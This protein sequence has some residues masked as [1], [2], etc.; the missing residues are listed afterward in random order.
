MLAVSRAKRAKGVG[1]RPGAGTRHHPDEDAGLPPEGRAAAEAGQG[2]R[3]LARER[4][5]PASQPKGELPTMNVGVPKER[6]PFEYRVGLPPAG[7]ALFVKHG[8]TLY[9]ERGAGEGAG[10]SDDHYVREGAK[11]V[12]SKDEVYG[13]ADL[14]LKFARPLK[15]ELD[16][17]R[18]GLTLAG[19][20]HL[21]AARQDKIWMM[22][23][24]TFTVLAY[25]QIEYDDGYRPVLAPLSQIG[26][27]MVPQIASRLLQNDQGGRGILLGRVVGVPP[28]EIV[29]IGAGVVGTTAATAFSAAGAH[30]TVL[31]VD[32]R[33]LHQLQADSG[34]QVATMLSTPYNVSKLCTYADVI[35]GAVL[36]PGSRAPIVLTREMVASMKPRSVIIDMSIDEG[37]CVETSRPTT[38]A[39]PTYIEEGVI[40]FCVPN[41]SGVLGRTGTTA[42]FNGAYPYLEAIARLGVEAA[43]DTIPALQRGVNALRGEVVNLKRLGGIGG[44]KE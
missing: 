41:M 38:Y 17:M 34:A 27:L 37:G 20:L 5:L 25:E 43:I 28:A 42:L 12:Y 9:I 6:R 11:I 40:H 16:L 13:R 15:D 35:V 29:I 31:D 22:L 18:P 4:P 21:A 24:K 1:A 39:S 33:R 10:F 30:V 19:F 32:L 36:A 23:E 3:M 14:L 26:G 8:H 2:L 44:V 7:A